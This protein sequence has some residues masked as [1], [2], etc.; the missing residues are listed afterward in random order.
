MLSRKNSLF[1]LAVIILLT[2]LCIAQEPK[3]V[4]VIEP[5]A[6][7]QQAK[8]NAFPHIAL[9]T[10]DN[11]YVRAGNGTSHYKCGKL[12]AG[13]K[14]TVVGSEYGWSKILP[15][16]GSFSWISK[17]F[18][19]LE[20]GN[21]KIG[22]VT[23]DTVRVWAGSNDYDPLR[24]I[25]LQTKLNKGDIV[26]RIGPETSGYYK[27]VPPTGAYLWISNQFIKY[28]GPVTRAQ[29][30]SNLEETIGKTITEP[31]VPSV[32]K[33]QD[34]ISAKTQTSAE[35][36]RLNQCRELGKLIEVERK[37]PA[38]KQNFSKIKVS[39][40][41]IIKDPEAGKAK[42]Y[43]EYLSNL[44]GRFE[45]AVIAK[46][47]LLKQDYELAAATEKIK[48]RLAAELKNI[49]V[50]SQFTVTG[51]LKSSQIFTADS[52]IQR[53]LIVSDTGKVIC[54]AIPADTVVEKNVK[55][56]INKKVTLAGEV[57]QNPYSAITLVSFSEINP[58]EDMQENTRK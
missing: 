57:I 28:F 8:A 20:E 14:V 17:D 58:P 2:S 34:P 22:T 23:N 52:G 10:G 25:G 9:V 19:K 16:Q 53:Y 27:I 37:K 44:V 46:D 47:A 33:M 41:E 36:K 32:D 56:S 42:L 15:P 12:N 43:A 13:Q 38:E 49:P 6:V 51:T 50:E 54:Y 29:T 7:A 18:V 21:D 26:Q 3:S 39:I 30:R 1:V 35:F 40:E 31:A 24:S 11:V 4:P 48:E 5:A 55:Q 45:L